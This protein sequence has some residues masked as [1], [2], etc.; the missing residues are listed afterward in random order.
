M[1]WWANEPLRNHEMEPERRL[2]A[3]APHK[4]TRWGR[5]GGSAVSLVQ[6]SKCLCQ[7]ADGISKRGLPNMQFLMEVLGDVWGHSLSS[8]HLKDFAGRGLNYTVCPLPRSG[9][10]ATGGGLDS[11]P[12]IL[13]R[14]IPI[15]VTSQCVTSDPSATLPPLTNPPKYS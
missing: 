14:Q 9:L 12:P 8:S 2:R 15:L 5:G 10:H 11:G 3:V 4:S 7:D 1:D 6:H 13:Q